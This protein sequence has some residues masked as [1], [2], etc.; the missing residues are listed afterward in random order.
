MDSQLLDDLVVADRKL[1]DIQDVIDQAK[2]D[3]RS[4]MFEEDF[5]SLAL[6]DKID[7]ILKGEKNG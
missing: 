2:L 5:D 1:S 4:V 7:E 6:I 3:W